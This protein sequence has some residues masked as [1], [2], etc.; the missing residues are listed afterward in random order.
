MNADR[1]PT[2]ATAVV[3]GRMQ[4]CH[5]G[6]GTLVR[7]ALALADRVVVVLGSAFHARDARNPFGWQER[8]AMVRATLTP[9]QRERVHF[10]PVRDYH[11]NDRWNVAVRKGV[12]AHQAPAGDT[13]LVGLEKDASSYYLAHFPGWHQH[14]VPHEHAIDATALRK[15]YFEGGDPDAALAVLEPYVDTGVIDYLR[16]WSKLPAYGQL[17]RESRAV[18]QGRHRFGPGPHLAAD[19][20]VQVGQHVLLVRRGGDVGHG[21]WAIPG[22]FVEIDEATEAAAL[23]ELREETRFPWLPDAIMRGRQGSAFFQAPGRS[24][25]G[26]ILSHAFHYRYGPMPLPEVLASDDAKEARWFHV[27][28]LSAM[29]EQ[30]FEDHAVILDRFIGGVLPD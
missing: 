10:V 4:P 11:D 17:V 7:Q 28:S 27:D 20:L 9:A 2:F 14:R 16:A 3:I 8:A 25:R 6:H 21:L 30:F 5:L 26:R 19:A 22:G 13:V 18:A 29:E 23:R 24:A 1:A 15:V 12:A